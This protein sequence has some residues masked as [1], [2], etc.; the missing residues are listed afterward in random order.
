MLSSII[1][2][3]KS[4]GKL[5]VLARKKPQRRGAARAILGGCMV[6][7]VVFIT[8]FSTWVTPFDPNQTSLTERLRPG[9]WAGNINHPFGT[10]QLGR[11]VLSRTMAGGQI[12]LSIT[13]AAVF[14]HAVIGTVL[15]LL[16]AYFG[17]LLDAIISVIGELFL[18]LPAILLIILFL[19]LLG[20]SVA[21]L[22]FVLAIENWVGLFR[23]IR[24]SVL[25]EKARDYT[26]AARIIGATSWRI[27]FRHLFPNILPTMLVM[28]TLSI[29]SVIL[30]EAG[31]SYLGF[32]V[33][34]PHPSWG[35]MIN[36]GQQ[37]I[38]TAWWVSTFPALTVAIMVLGINL[39][40]DGL[41]QL[42]KM[43]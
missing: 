4:E 43:E 30:S 37:Y 11:D 2:S 18:A 40:G 7:I 1:T 36:D 15:G 34:R 39:L 23:L 27:I 32:G 5:V 29:G 14:G 6:G 12:S 33:A 41:R 16:S 22:A 13:L 42:W 26:D 10:D 24:G 31:L 28:I 38:Q 8:I 19:A 35:R 21:T 3:G 25:S 20:P 9:I 17:G